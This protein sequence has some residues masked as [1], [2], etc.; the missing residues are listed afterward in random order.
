[1]YIVKSKPAWEIGWD[2]VMILL[3]NEDNYYI[4]VWDATGHWVWAWF[5]MIMVNALVSWFAKVYKSLEQA[6]LCKN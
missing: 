3:M 5:I 2:S 4:Y 6:I 1:M